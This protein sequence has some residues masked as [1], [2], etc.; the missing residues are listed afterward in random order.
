[1]RP[2][3]LRWACERAGDSGVALRE[4]HP[5]LDEW[6]RGDTKPT[7]KQLE[8]FAKAARVPLG[9]LFLPAPPKEPL[10]IRDLRTLGGKGV[11]SPSPDLLDT[12]YLC[13][14]RQDWYREYAKQ[15]EE[16]PIAFI[17][18]A[19]LSQPVEEVAEQMRRTFRYEAE[20]RSDCRDTSDAL[21]LLI[22]RAEEVG[23]LVMVSGVV[24]NSTARRL[25]PEEFRG[26]AIADPI[27][28][29]VFVNAADAKPAQLF[30]LAHELAH[31]W[32]GETALSDAS[33]RAVGT[34]RIEA[35]C[36][37]VAAEFLVPLAELQAMA[38]DSPLDYLDSYKERFH[39]SRLV[40]LRRLLDASLIDHEQFNSQY[41]AFSRA[42][43]TTSRSGGGDFYATL[44]YRASR[45]FIRA[46][47]TNT[48]EG[49]TL[50]RDAFQLLGISSE[51]T[52]RKIGQKVGGLA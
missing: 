38:I 29:L 27:A 42:P 8:R 13:Q 50:Y 46:L 28:P 19:T 1:V 20:A 2:E 22:E 40:I 9:Y 35:W 30:T 23:V 4:N 21:R 25:D 15:Q 32:L 41:A 5:L 16:D 36:N 52:F 26:F 10:P 6:V 37:R 3:L 48:L 47:V 11:R 33:L 51:K 34:N 31:L 44:P 45:R 18:A 49:K 39:V 7:L 12:I 24:K 43:T 14:R 17:G